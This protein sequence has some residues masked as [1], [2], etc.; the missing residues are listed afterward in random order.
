MKLIPTSI[1]NLFNKMFRRDKAAAQPAPASMETAVAVP[2]AEEQAKI[3]FEKAAARKAEYQAQRL[4]SLN[5]FKSQEGVYTLNMDIS[6]PSVGPKDTA[7]GGQNMVMVTSRDADFYLVLIG[8]TPLA[9]TK[10]LATS[11]ENHMID[12]FGLDVGKVYFK[13]KNENFYIDGYDQFTGLPSGGQYQIVLVPEDV[14]WKPPTYVPPARPALPE[15]CPLISMPALPPWL[16][17]KL[18][19]NQPPKPNPFMPKG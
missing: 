3:A 11:I 4:A 19:P 17:A 16:Y 9:G 12:K 18:N 6:A 14:Q 10:A 5:I 1:K 13:M 15:S 7:F 2:T 8:N